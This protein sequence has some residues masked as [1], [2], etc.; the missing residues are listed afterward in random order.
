MRVAKVHVSA[1]NES[2]T[3]TSQKSHFR[4]TFI[5]FSNKYDFLSINILFINIS[6]FVAH[7]IAHLHKGSTQ[8]EKNNQI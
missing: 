2:Q 6:Y 7:L 5:L 4:H 1:L 3:Q 8:E